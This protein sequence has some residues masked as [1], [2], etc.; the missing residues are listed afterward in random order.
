MY[1]GNITSS[2]V[3]AQVF[4]AAVAP[5]GGMHSGDLWVDSTDGSTY[6]YDGTSWTVLLAAHPFTVAITPDPIPATDSGKVVG[7]DPGGKI[8]KG[9]LPAGA[10]DF[11]GAID[12][13]VPVDPTLNPVDGFTY[14][15]NKNGTIDPSF[16]GI[17][18]Q[19]VKSGDM[20]SYLAGKWHLTPASNDLTAYVHKA[21]D[22]MLAGDNTRIT[23]SPAT[24]DGSVIVLDA[25]FG[26][27]DQ[28]FIDGGTF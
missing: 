25:A 3:T 19:T 8:D 26:A 28:S 22:R 16:T 12:V 1:Y 18:G 7:L 17:S 4:V 5:S 15:A 2:A 6:I 14:F 20:V 13:T 10:L 23:F 24:V 9:F 11:R 27:I 21:G